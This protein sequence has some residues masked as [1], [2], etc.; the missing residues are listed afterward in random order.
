VIIYAIEIC[1]FST[2]CYGETHIDS[3]WTTKEKAEDYILRKGL[4]DM[5]F[6]SVE[7]IFIEVDVDGRDY[8][9][10]YLD[11]KKEM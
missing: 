7:V 3:Y 1:T 4:L 11:K 10:K 8:V 5:K 2:D 9:N 6:P